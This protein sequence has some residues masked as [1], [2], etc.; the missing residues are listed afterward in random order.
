MNDTHEYLDPLALAKARSP[1]L[2]ARLIAEGYLSGLHK[3]PYHGFS[4]EVCPPGRPKCPYRGFSVES[5]E[6]REYVPGDDLKPLAWKVYSRLGRFYIKQY[7]E[8]TNLNL[9]LLV[10]TS[11]S[12]RYGSGKKGDDG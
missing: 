11:E 10:D 9:W 12:M 5:V 1:E 7:E 8:E 4:A 2:Q 6:H 3:S